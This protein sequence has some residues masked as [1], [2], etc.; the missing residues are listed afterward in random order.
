MDE[1]V[2]LTESE[3]TLELLFQF[4]YPQRH[5]DLLNLPFDILD[6]L[7][8]AVEKYEVYPAMNIATVRMQSVLCTPIHKSE[9]SDSSSTLQICSLLT[10]GSSFELRL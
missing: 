9:H 2:P 8:E 7:A 6:S 4:I 1:I 10:S 3:S 5:P